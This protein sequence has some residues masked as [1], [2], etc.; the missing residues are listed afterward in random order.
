M[1]I[2]SITLQTC[3][4]KKTPQDNSTKSSSIGSKTVDDPKKVA[5]DG[6]WVYIL[7]KK[8]VSKKEFEEV[9][10]LFL[11][12]SAV[13]QGIGKTQLS[14]FRDRVEYKKDVMNRIINSTLGFKK[15]ITD[16]FFQ[17]KEGKN[18]LQVLYKQAL[19]QYFLYKNIYENYKEP[20][21]EDVE[22]HYNQYKK[23][24]NKLGLK[25]IKSDR[26]KAAVKNHLSNT[27]VASK[28]NELFEKLI[29][30]Y[31]I[32][33]N[34]KVLSEYL[35]KKISKKSAIDDPKKEYWVIKVKGKPL[36][37]G[38]IAYFLDLMM[39]NYKITDKMLENTDAK[40]QFIREL[41]NLLK[42]MEL[43]YR[44]ALEKKMHKSSE[45]EKFVEIVQKRSVSLFYFMK[46]VMAEIKP[47]DDKTI[48]ELLK[49]KSKETKVIELLK[50]RKFPVNKKNIMEASKQILYEE[51][52]TIAQTEFIKELREAHQIRISEAYFK[53]TS[54]KIKDEILKDKKK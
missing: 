19:Y 37:L 27:T 46:K 8:L 34:K 14:L 17:S 45:G 4:S 48:N 49:D 3:D 40:D 9:Y 5:D 2:V 43:S 52:I 30:E 44:E 24:F 29:N 16:P 26:N 10:D 53:S 31:T 47:P 21:E 13:G 11:K 42:T 7:D 22:K 51:K 23:E 41:L 54:D 33:S 50:Q 28:T 32:V 39:K 20:T 18:L 15:A 1:F 35:T 6:T 36:Y 38:Q 12:V 25:D